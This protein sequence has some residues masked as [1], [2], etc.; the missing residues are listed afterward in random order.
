MLPLSPKL[1]SEVRSLAATSTVEAVLLLRTATGCSLRE[2]VDAL[3]ILVPNPSLEDN[4][5]CAEVFAFGPFS[6]A[7]SERM[8]YGASH[9]EGLAPDTP[10]SVC[11]AEVNGTAS[12]AWLAETVGIADPDDMNQWHV[13]PE[14]IDALALEQAGHCAATQVDALR[15]AGFSFHF[16]IAPS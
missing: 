9:F 6:T 12:V 2:A 5:P 11:I 4:P 7:L 3:R 13:R 8:D 14:A 15:S 1:S 16:V 10:V